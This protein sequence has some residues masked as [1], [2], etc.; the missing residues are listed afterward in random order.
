MEDDDLPHGLPPV[1]FTAEQMMFLEHLNQQ[2]L[3]VQWDGLDNDHCFDFSDILNETEPH[4]VLDPVQ[5]LHSNMTSFPS[6]INP[7]VPPFRPPVPQ[8]KP[9]NGEVGGMTGADFAHNEHA[10]TEKARSISVEDLGGHGMNKTQIPD[11]V[12]MKSVESVSKSR[13]G[14]NSH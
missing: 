9:M 11:G 2:Q 1:S 12:P 14:M 13:R 7:L 10:G 3:Q 6:R 8:F 5:N 4:V